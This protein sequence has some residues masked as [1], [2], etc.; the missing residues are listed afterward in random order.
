MVI[1][2]YGTM[3]LLHWLVP[4]LPSYE[5]VDLKTCV[6]RMRGNRKNPKLVSD[7]TDQFSLT[8][9]NSYMQLYT[10]HLPHRAGLPSGTVW[11]KIDVTQVF[12]LPVSYEQVTIT[13]K[14][15][16]PI[17]VFDYR[18]H[19]MGKKMSPI[20]LMFKETNN[21]ILNIFKIKFLSCNCL[22]QN[23]KGWLYIWRFQRPH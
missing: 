1:S 14:N 7:A 20:D 17:T 16:G 21:N 11:R 18:R 4:L 23:I 2:S 12:T 10:L 22:R 9:T 8:W 19:I 3:L 6:N 15:S 13:A 5:T